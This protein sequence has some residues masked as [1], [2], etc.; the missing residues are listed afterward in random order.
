MNRRKFLAA[1]T[2]AAGSAATVLASNS[3]R[4][5]PKNLSEPAF[6]QMAIATI[7]MDGF[8]DEN[9]APSFDIA[10]K[11]GIRNIEFN[12]WY[13]RNLTPAGLEGI[14][15]R[16]ARAGL[17]PIGV[18]GNAFTDG[19]T[20][21]VAHKL[22]CLEA[23]R[24]LGARR[25]KFTGSKRGT[26]GG[27]ASVIA[28]L[29][30]LAPAAE[31]MGLLVLVENHAGNVL[32]NVADYEEIFSAIDS[33]NV[34][35][36]LDTGHFVGANVDLD[37][38]VE[39]FHTRTLHV[40][41]K[42]TEARGKYRTVNYGTGAVDLHRCVKELLAHG[43]AGYLLIEQAPPLNKETLFSDL[44]RGYEMFKVYER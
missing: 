36:C 18:Q 42:D 15:S 37:E 26:N 23:A 12:T 27:L 17:K 32:E 39:K 2:V 10:P 34:G 16:C 14:I 5:K 33:P 40:D 41:L 7:C 20:P 11:L 22:W 4:P 25:V 24:R 6:V 30:E 44:K 38:V 35:L 9:F 3:P 43:Y 21:D 28:A 29:K 1:A 19:K 31:A 8:G 13:P